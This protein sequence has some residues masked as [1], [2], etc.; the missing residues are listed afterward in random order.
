MVFYKDLSEG[1]AVADVFQQ[2]GLSWAGVLVGI[3]AMAG[4]TSVIL[5]D[6]VAMGRIG[7]A[8]AR[9][10]L[11]PPV[12]SKIHPTW[13]TPVLMTGITVVVVALL[14]GF[15]PISVLAEMVSIGTLFAF[16]VVS[17]AVPVLRRTQPDMK[18]PFRT[19][20]VPL[21]PVLSVLCCLALMSSLAM[22]TWLRFLAWLI[23]GFV[24]YFGYGMSHSRV[25]R[26]ERG[27]LKESV[28]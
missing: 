23:I 20:L 15:V 14:G 21:I 26:K 11:L 12:F 17:I 16:L 19:P 18:R 27:A 4:L 7:F 6:L 28:R 10:G 3:A 1:D 8:I 2:V 24:V 22:E 9:D 25:G 5:V 13:G